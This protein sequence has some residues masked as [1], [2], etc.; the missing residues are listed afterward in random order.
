MIHE[1]KSEQ[2]AVSGQIYIF[3]PKLIQNKSTYSCHDTPSTQIHY[4]MRCGVTKIASSSRWRENKHPV[5][6]LPVQ[7]QMTNYL[8]ALYCCQVCTAAQLIGTMQSMVLANNHYTGSNSSLKDF[9]G[10]FA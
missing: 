6:F 7:I 10:N 4:I 3:Y 2:Y 5:H 9:L 8:I 1:Q